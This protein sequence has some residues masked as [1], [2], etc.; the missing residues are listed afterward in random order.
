MWKHFSQ[1]KSCVGD[2]NHLH[3]HNWGVW[4]DRHRVWSFSLTLHDSRGSDGRLAEAFRGWK[5]ET[6][7]WQ[8][9]WDLG[10]G[11]RRSFAW[12]Q[13]RSWRDR[14]NVLH[15][16]SCFFFHL[17]YRERWKHV[18][19]SS[20][21]SF[22][23]TIR[24]W[25]LCSDLYWVNIAWHYFFY[26]RKT[27]WGVCGTLPLLGGTRSGILGLCCFIEGETH[28]SRSEAGVS[29]RAHICLYRGL[30]QGKWPPCDPPWCHRVGRGRSLR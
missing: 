20:R 25:L 26:R 24:F 13:R 3:L 15:H 22:L 4:C 7:R 11:R 18:K 6:E 19:R 1:V 10:D 17:L 23:R 30:N 21:V 2:V 16:F 8:R 5:W 14:R 9:L 27:Q 28:G 12:R 29:R